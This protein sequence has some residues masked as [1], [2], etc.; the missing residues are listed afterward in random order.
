[1][2]K[3]K[4]LLFGRMKKKICCEKEERKE[5]DKW[6][7]FLWSLRLEKIGRSQIFTWQ[8]FYVCWVRLLFC[9]CSETS[10]LLLTLFEKKDRYIYIPVP[11]FFAVTIFFFCVKCKKKKKQ[12]WI[13]RSSIIFKKNFI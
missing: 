1:L 10:L 6:G 7:L 8:F 4:K 13:G 9:L 2:T 5:G 3:K 11:H 12:G